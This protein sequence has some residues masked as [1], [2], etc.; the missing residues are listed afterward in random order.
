[1]AS[2]SRSNVWKGDSGIL[3]ARFRAM[4]EP[5][6]PR[7]MKPRDGFDGDIVEF[8]QCSFPGEKG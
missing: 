7:P 2:W 8:E 4:R 5:M 3:I 1:M 6:T